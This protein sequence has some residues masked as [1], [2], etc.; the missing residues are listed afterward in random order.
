MRLF[1]G[2][3]HKHGASRTEVYGRVGKKSEFCEFFHAVTERFR[4]SLQK[5]AAT[6]RTR[7]VEKELVDEIVSYFEALHILPADVENKVDVGA[8]FL[9]GGV[10]RHG[11]HQ[12]V[13]YTEGVFYHFFAVTRYRRP[14]YFDIRKI[15]VKFFEII[16]NDFYG[17]A[18]ARGVKRSDYVSFFVREENFDRG[19][20]SVDAEENFSARSVEFGNAFGVPSVPKPELFVFFFVFEKGRAAFVFFKRRRFLE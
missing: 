4:E 5:R 2:T 11:F 17:F 15:R 10:M 19:R 20:T 14:R 9:R 6:G 16:E 7:F 8:E 1:H 13:V 18:H 3:V 12:S